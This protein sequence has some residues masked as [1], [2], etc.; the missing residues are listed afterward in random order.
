VSEPEQFLVRYIG[1]YGLKF[2]GTLVRSVIDE[3]A[4][5][6]NSMEEAEAAIK[7]AKLRRSTVEIDYV[8]KESR[9]NT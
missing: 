6:F 2:E 7:A 4:T 1:A 9:E 8:R 3:D 5:R